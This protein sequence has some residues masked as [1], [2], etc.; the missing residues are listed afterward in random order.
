[1]SDST[2]RTKV[3]RRSGDKELLRNASQLKNAH[4]NEMRK[5]KRDFLKRINYHHTF[6]AVVLP[7]AALI[8]MFEYQV[9]LVPANIRTLI[10]SVVYFNLT[11]LA[12]SAGYHKCF[13]HNSFRPRFRVVLAAFAV[14]GAGVG[15]GSIRWWASLHRAHH[16]FTDDTEKDPFSIKR[17]FFWAHWGWLVK[18]PKLVSFYDEF[19]EQ[20]FPTSANRNLVREVKKLQ[21]IETD[22]FEYEA[23]DLTHQ[24][25]TLETHSLILWQDKAYEVL[26]VLSGLLLPAVITRYYCHDTWINGLLYPGVIR[27]FLCQQCMLST[28]SV[29]HFR[30]IQVTIPT[31]PFNDKNSSIN[32]NNPLVSFLTYGQAKQNY[33][34]EFPHDYRGLSSMFAFDPTKWF[35]WTL[36]QLYLVEDLHRTP[37]DLIMQL[38]IQQQQEAIN[39]MKS[40]L[41]WGTPISKLPVISAR[42]FNQLVQSPKNSDRMYIVIQQIIHDVTPFMDQHP[43]GVPL[44]K[45][46]RGKDATRAFY[47]GVY[48]HS[49]AAVNLLATMR[50]AV[51]DSGNDE[52]VWRRVVL[53]ENEVSTRARRDS[54]AYRTAEAA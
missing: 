26:F 4:I 48:G 35:I 29:C 45:A 52:D 23:E 7:A 20:E 50:I 19:I 38:Q 17:G 13:T 53:E 36:S 18:K 11:M 41:N 30:A 16:Q 15:L 32:C 39:R 12:F 43:G 42:E 25:Y 40:L 54:K 34:H 3:R 21:G 8:Y 47:G 46:S 10:F 14:L 27:M 6:T 9:A 5:R 31:Q 28:E 49:T 2:G 33:H 24:N 37:K 44:L 22:D 1:M 51:L